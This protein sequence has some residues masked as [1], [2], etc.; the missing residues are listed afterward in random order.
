MLFVVADFVVILL[1]TATMVHRSLLAWRNAF[2]AAS[3]SFR[4]R[5][6]R[7]FHETVAIC[8][9]FLCSVNSRNS[10]I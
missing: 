3:T 9:P 1:F 10:V 5:N 2:A 6:G 4:R 8:F 7:A